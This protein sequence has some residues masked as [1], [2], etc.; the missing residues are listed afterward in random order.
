MV[1]DAV[2]TGDRG[3]SE[4]LIFVRRAA[5]SPDLCLSFVVIVRLV[6]RG[7]LSWLARSSRSDRLS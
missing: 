7:L 5:H 6:G 3:G 4:L 2:Q 1:A